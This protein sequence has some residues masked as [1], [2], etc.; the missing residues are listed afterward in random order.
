MCSTVIHQPEYLPWINLFTKMS[1][2]ETFVFLDNVQYQ[3]RSYQNRNLVLLNGNSKFLTVPIK[4]APQQTLISNIKIDNSQ[5]WIKSHINI[6]KNCYQKTKYFEEVF[7]LIV[8]EYKKKFVFLNDL[9]KSLTVSIAKKLKMQCRFL[10]ATNMNVTGQKSDLILDIC[11]KSNTHKYITG[12]GSKSY[13]D[14]KKFNLNGIKIIYLEPI[15]FR[16]E[17]V[18]KISNFV[19]NLSIIDFLFNQGFEKFKYTGY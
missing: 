18:N 14:I 7:E 16:Y 4:Y 1:K 15:N 19:P 2:C 10:S 5:E 3:R 17:Q 6:I 9:N 11:K 8:N 12:T 13:L